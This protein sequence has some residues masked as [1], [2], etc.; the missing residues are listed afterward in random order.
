MPNSIVCE[1]W[2]GKNP[3][4]AAIAATPAEVKNGYLFAPTGAGLGIGLDAEAL[5]RHAVK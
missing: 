5:L 3:I 2:I 1:Y 4:G